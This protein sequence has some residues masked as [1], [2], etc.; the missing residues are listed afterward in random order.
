MFKHSKIL[1]LFIVFAF[2]FVLTGLA[3]PQTDETVVCPVSGKEIKK[4]EAKGS[5]EYKSKTYYFCCEGCKEKF[6]KNPEKFIQKKAEKKE[7]CSC[8]MC[9]KVESEKGCQLVEC[10]MMFKKMMM[11]MMHMHGKGQKHGHMMHMKTEEKAC[12]PLMSIK[13][14]DVKVENLEDGVAVRITSKN[15]DVV[16]KIQETA[17]N[18][19]AGSC[20][21]KEESGKK[22]E[23]KVEKK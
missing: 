4:S 13:D 16:K 11:T 12:C 21:E 3:Q 18:L 19:K 23:K 1:A 10:E 17:V 6:I 8:P 22:E 2:V 9:S 20:C 7:V 15:A 5:Y 14:A